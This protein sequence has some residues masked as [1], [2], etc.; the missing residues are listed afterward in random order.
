MANLV[1]YTVPSA[2]LAAFPAAALN[3]LPN[4]SFVLGDI[5]TNETALD[6]YGELSVSL[7]VQTGASA[8]L[9]VWMLP[10]NHLGTAYGDGTPTGTV[11]PGSGYFLGNLWLRANQVSSVQSGV[12]GPITLRPNSFR[13]GLSNAAGFQVATAGGTASFRT[14]TENL[15]GP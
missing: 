6:L 8:Y 9:G 10:L 11:L 14:W 5:E 15:N 2:W 7:T 1:K 12:F 3:D 13:F 4:G